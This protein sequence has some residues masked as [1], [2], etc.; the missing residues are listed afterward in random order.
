MSNMSTKINKER[1]GSCAQGLQIDPGL[2]SSA[3]TFLTDKM[4][5]KDS[6]NPE[7]FCDEM[8][9]VSLTFFAMHRWSKVRIF[10]I[11]IS[12]HKPLHGRSLISVVPLVG[13]V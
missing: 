4:A 13:N 3:L 12:A 9:S 10:P 8:T 7:P 5:M 11:S 2:R 1:G 6:K